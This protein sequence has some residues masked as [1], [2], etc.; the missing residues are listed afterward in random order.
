MQ[1]AGKKNAN[2]EFY[3]QQDY[4]LKMEVKL[5]HSQGNKNW[6][7]L[8]QVHLTREFFRLKASDPR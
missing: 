2:Q 4:P 3:T 6:E 1:S 7:V 5:S 8:W